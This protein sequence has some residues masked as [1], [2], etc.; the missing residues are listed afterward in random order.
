VAAQQQARP[1]SPSRL[2]HVGE[3]DRWPPFHAR[4]EGTFRCGAIGGPYATI[5]VVV[6]A[7]A[8]ARRNAHGDRCAMLVNRT[9]I[10][11]TVSLSRWQRELTLHGCG[12]ATT[13]E[14][15]P[16]RTGIDLRV[17]IIT[18]YMPITSDGKAPN[19]SCCSR[20]IREV[21]GK[22]V[23][24][25]LRA[26]PPEPKDKLSQKAVMRAHL[27]PVFFVSA[28]TRLPYCRADRYLPFPANSSSSFA[29]YSW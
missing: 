24:R 12:L 21:A 4:G 19:L 27:P 22:A 2:G 13:I 1:V 14:A 3:V 23:R 8:S 5:P 28:I 20:V 26:E 16:G 15:A 9:P 17:N 11:G 25:A 7:W 29:S 10:T 6:E 18:P